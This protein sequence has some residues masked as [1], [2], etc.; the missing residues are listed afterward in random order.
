MN[1]NVV[2]DIELMIIIV[3][4]VVGLGR[5]KKHVHA[6]DHN[7]QIIRKKRDE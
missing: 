7:V 6:Q 2:T 4:L 1:L 5:R 3:L